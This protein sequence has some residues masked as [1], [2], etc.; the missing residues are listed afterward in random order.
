MQSVAPG[1]HLGYLV[2]RVRTEMIAKTRRTLVAAA[3]A[4][5]ATAAIPG[6]AHA[7]ADRGD[8]AP[9]PEFVPGE[10]LVRFKPA[11]SGEERTDVRREEGVSFEASLPVPGL[12]K[13]ETDPGT[14]PPAAARD[15][16]RR[17]EVLYAQPNF[18][19]EVAQTQPES[20]EE[21]FGE[22]W[23]LDNGGAGIRTTQGATVGSTPDA[24]IDAPEAWDLETGDP[25]VTVAVVDGGVDY[26]HPDL[27]GNVTR[28]AN[29]DVLGRDFCGRTTNQ[30]CGGPVDTDPMDEDPLGH[31]TH[32][33]GTIGADGSN[34][35]GLLG[36][37]WDVGLLPVRVANRNGVTTDALLTQGF[38]W[39]VDRGASVLNAS[40]GG[41]GPAAAEALQ[42]V[43]RRSRGTLFVVAA[44]NDGTN[45]E[46]DPDFLCNIEAPNL[47]CVTA[48]DQ[49][50]RRPGF[51]SFGRR[52]VDLAAPGANILSTV[53]SPFREHFN[54]SSW[55][56]SWTAQ[57]LPWQVE[58]DPGEPGTLAVTESPSID[59]VPQDYPDGAAGSLTSPR[60]DTTVGTREPPLDHCF[61][62]YRMRYELGA[63]DT[64]KVQASSN[65]FA[66]EG[67]ELA[68]YPDPPPTPP[69]GAA[70][71]YEYYVHDLE[72]LFTGSNPPLNRSRFRIQFELEADDAAGDD[73]QADGVYID[74]VSVECYER[75][76]GTSMA[77]PHAAGA[78]ALLFAESGAAA[79]AGGVRRTLIASVDGKSDFATR[80]V[81]GGRLNAARA[82]ARAESPPPAATLAGGPA[83]WTRDAT[84]PYDF[85]ATD[86]ASTFQCRL[87]GGAPYNCDARYRLPSS[88]ADGS[89]TLQVRAR[90]AG[91]APIP[92]ADHASA[93]SHSFIL[94]T[95]GPRMG[96][97]A[98]LTLDRRQIRVDLR[99]PASEPF[100]RCKG[101]M[102]LR[103]RGKVKTGSGRRTLKLGSA[104]FSIPRAD[105]RRSVV[106][107]SKADRQILQRV[108]SIRVTVRT[109]A[110]DALGNSRV[111][112]R[113]P[114]L[115]VG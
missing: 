66:S 22:L 83:F 73:T 26:E 5:A 114:L 14:S 40:F 34:G 21:L 42:D 30:I 6:I 100:G 81:S 105:D 115:R 20:G 86:S 110:R 25:S 9:P 62:R 85:A 13:V 96:I 2:G 38:G 49:N 58:E 104:S 109:N 45:N 33:A 82:V 95:T 8:A 61:L 92:F 11:V 102:T 93:P 54:D 52:S 17:P 28:R 46:V 87:N 72:P 84:T 44:G 48:S 71:P 98:P 68:T 111:T 47:L 112:T 94:D 106:R 101:N 74:D 39:A 1:G 53:P 24:D 41:K 63:D 56:Q 91:G 78:A 19:R 59:G 15:L 108:G 3:V 55:A 80:T 97:E 23:G 27:A 88:L 103:S 113:Q 43:I 69:D 70:A 36:V 57:G 7:Q 10:V 77:T 76:N 37:N 90:N 12:Q 32:V 16:E 18:V 107:I 29:G 31:G 64:L 60:V 50:D 75:M 67:A 4:A 99:C 79:T 65:D 89:Y 51:A 35:F